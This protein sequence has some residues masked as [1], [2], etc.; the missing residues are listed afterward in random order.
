MVREAGGCRHQGDGRLSAV[1]ASSRGL[2]ASRCAGDGRPASVGDWL[3]AMT[4]NRVARLCDA[5]LVRYAAG[6]PHPSRFADTFSRKR[7]KDPRIVNDRGAP[8]MTD[9]PIGGRVFFSNVRRS[10]EEEDEIR[11]VSVG[12]DIGSSTSH[13]VFS[14]LVLERLD[15]RYVVSRARDRA[16]IRR[17]ADALCRRYDD[18]RRGARPLHRPPVRAGRTRSAGDR[19]RRADPDGRRRAAQ[20]CAGDRRAVRGPDRQVRLGQRRRRAR[21]HARRFR[22]GRRRALDPRRR[23]GDE[24]RRRRRHVEDRASAQRASSSK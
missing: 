3:A 17:P 16:R 22:F 23:A 1:A 18:R 19:H 2:D 24:Y 10:L 4:R 9:E 11:L 6:D 21:D 7:E 12:V 15:N 13:L 5:T 8:V 20:Q 14:R